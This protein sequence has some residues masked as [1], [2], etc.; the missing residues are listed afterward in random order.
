MGL[1]LCVAHRVLAAAAP[2]FG[3]AEREAFERHGAARLQ[4]AA[5][6]D[7]AVGAAAN[8]GTHEIAGAERLRYQAPRLEGLSK[9]RLK[10]M[11]SRSV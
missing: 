11:S 10:S 4:A 1:G 6:E 5:T 2:P 7:R 9:A 8:L 3:R